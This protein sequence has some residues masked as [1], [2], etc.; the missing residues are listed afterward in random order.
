MCVAPHLQRL[1]GKSEHQKDNSDQKH[2]EQKDRSGKVIGHQSTGKHA[3]NYKNTNDK[4]K[5]S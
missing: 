5:V 3:R 4:E 1:T 2:Y